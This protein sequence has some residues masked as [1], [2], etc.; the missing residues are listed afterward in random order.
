MVQEYASSLGAGLTLL[1]LFRLNSTLAKTLGV[2]VVILT[3]GSLFIWLRYPCRSPSSLVGVIAQATTVFKKCSATYAFERGEYDRYKTLLHRATARALGIA[4]RTYHSADRRRSSNRVY[5]DKWL[6]LWKRLK[7]V[8]DCH[9]ETQL[10]IRDLE[11]C[12]M[13][14]SYS[15]ADYELHRAPLI[16][17]NSAPLRIG[18][19]YSVELEALV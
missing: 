11:M 19:G 18:D 2:V 4:S 6:F 17:S 14:A 13:R 12:L 9:R 15:R 5:L 1:S 16:R 10:L 8:V 3:I 7:D